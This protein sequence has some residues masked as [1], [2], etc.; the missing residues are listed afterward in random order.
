VSFYE[1][2]VAFHIDRRRCFQSS[3]ISNAGAAM[4]NQDYRHEG[5]SFDSMPDIEKYFIPGN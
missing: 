3:W 4:T 1:S 5:M 2:I